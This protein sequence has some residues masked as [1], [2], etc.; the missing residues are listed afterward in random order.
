MKNITIHKNTL[1]TILLLFVLF[2]LNI[3]RNIDNDLSNYIEIFN[4]FYNHDFLEIFGNSDFL[5]TVKPSEP[6]FYFT[7]FLFSKLFFGK[8]YLYVG[9]ITLIFYLNFIFGIYKLLRKFEVP[10]KNN[11]SYI[12]ILIFACIN[13]SE[14]SHLLRQYFAASFLPLLIFYLFNKNILKVIFL[15]VFIVLTHN[16]L[17]III[18]LLFLSKFY[19]TYYSRYIL[20]TNVLTII[21]F[22]LFL[23]Y[24]L[25]YLNALSYFDEPSDI[26]YV[27]IYYDFLILALYFTFTFTLKKKLPLWNGFFAIFS[28]LYLLFLFNLT[29]SE[30][31]FLRFY[32][33][34]EWFR[35]FY[36]III[37]FSLKILQVNKFY[38]IFFYFA[39]LTVFILRFVVSPWHYLTFDLFL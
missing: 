33:N 36:F 27:S 13:F 34:I 39:I 16:S 32:L 29:F 22:T 5:F 25:N 1:F 37:L 20:L 9:A 30:T 23:F 26:K 17:L 21:I 3:S 18:F 6:V 28:I 12:C 8:I 38:K 11:F 19:Y 35:F 7:T 31:V 2:F 15:S 10:E 4:F 14:T 24:S